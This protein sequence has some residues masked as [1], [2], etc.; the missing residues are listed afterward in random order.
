VVGSGGAVAHNQLPHY[1]AGR[2]ADQGTGQDRP[3]GTVMKFDSFGSP[4]MALLMAASGGDPSSESVRRLMAGRLDWTKLTRLAFESHATPGLWHV[5]SSFPDLPAEA[6][7]LQSLA[8]VNDFRRYHIRSLTA[9]VTR[10]LAAEGIEVLALKGAAL[11]AG[12]VSRPAQRTMADIDLLVIAGSPEHAWKICRANGWSLVNEATMVE[13]YQGHHHLPPL[14]DPDGVTIGLELH[15]ALLP[16]AERLG[17]DLPAIIARSRVVKVGEVPVRV[18]SVEDLLLHAC[19][20]FAWSNKLRRGV[21]R[22]FADVHAI[23]ADPAFDWDRFVS[24]AV[25]RR[26]KQCC[27]WTLRLGRVVVEMSVPDEVLNRLDPSSGGP[28][29]SFLERHFAIQIA[30]P[31][32][33]EAVA[34]RVQRWLWF[35]GMREPSRSDEADALWNEGSL[36]MPRE[37]AN[38]PPQRGAL[39]AALA[40]TQYFFRLISRE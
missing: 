17:V 28:L 4:E 27:Y 22:A 37:D 23:I 20:H 21:W 25:T 32:A 26:A 39:R 29:S 12:G 16:G 24:V 1:N 3:R 2:T 7:T 13:L 5:V 14:L 15:R 18:P 40:T 35:A 10:E 38:H 11:L 19:L 6:E 36:A 34:E 33:E 9:R 30:D 31:G 8:V